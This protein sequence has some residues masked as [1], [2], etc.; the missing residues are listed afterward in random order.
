[1][2]KDELTP[3]LIADAMNADDFFARS[4]FE[5]AGMLLG[6]ALANVANLLD[7]HVFILGGGV[8]GAGEVLFDVALATLRSRV[9]ANLRPMVEIRKAHLGNRAGMI[10]AAMLVAE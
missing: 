2:E 9:L 6:V 7:M 3:K 10:G 1:M 5:E 8:A 4:V